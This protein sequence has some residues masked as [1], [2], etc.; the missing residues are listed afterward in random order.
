MREQDYLRAIEASP[1]EAEPRL[2]YAAWLDDRGRHEEAEWLRLDVLLTTAEPFPPYEQYERQQQLRP[3]RGVA[4]L[5]LALARRA[6]GDEAKLAEL[7]EKI[8]AG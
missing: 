7:L 6:G 4:P 3:P 2:R 8:G 5:W 1:S